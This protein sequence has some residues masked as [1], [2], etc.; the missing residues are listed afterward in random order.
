MK[1]KAAKECPVLVVRAGKTI[2]AGHVKTV[3]A[4]GRVM[5]NTQH[6][7]RDG[8]ICSC[9]VSI[10]G[11]F[12]PIEQSVEAVRALHAAHAHF[13]IK[14]DGLDKSD[15]RTILVDPAGVSRVVDYIVSCKECGV[16]ICRW[17]SPRLATRARAQRLA[18]PGVIVPKLR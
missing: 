14:H 16:D 11:M 4:E 18:A 15:N 9:G 2:R 1:K 6:T 10:I 3:R 8:R 17:R 5:K 7:L 12:K 13:W